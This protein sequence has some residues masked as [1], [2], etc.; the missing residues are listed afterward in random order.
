MLLWKYRLKMRNVA[1]LERGA[2]RRY[3]VVSKFTAA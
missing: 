1:G 3:F 2:K